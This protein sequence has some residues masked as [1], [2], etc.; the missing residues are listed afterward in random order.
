M[1]IEIAWRSLEIE[2]QIAKDHNSLDT[3]KEMVS[4][5]NLRSLNECIILSRWNVGGAL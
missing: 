1:Y 5:K 3:E 4:S 2:R